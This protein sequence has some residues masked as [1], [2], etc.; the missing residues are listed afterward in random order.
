[1]P[2]DEAKLT[3][4]ALGILDDGENKVIQREIATSPDLQEELASIRSA[5]QR[6]ALAEKPI[7]PSD[8]LRD[9]VLDS[10]QTET[11][12]D[13]FIERFS[14]LFDL[15]KQSSKNLLAK[16]DHVS[17]RVWESTFFPGI[18]I[19]KFSAGPGVASDIC[20][21][22]QVKPGKLFPAHQH[23]GNEWTLIL[24]GQARDDKDRVYTAGDM[25]HYSAGSKHSFRIIGDETFIFAVNLEK[26][27]K[28]LLFR[29]FIDYLR[30]RK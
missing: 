22:V 3:E 13:G 9:L 21:I 27:N 4:Y 12:F 25:T 14:D 8:R 26:E 5:L 30:N 6:V 10:T 15:D 29:T 18:N 2:V 16:I 23:M 24:Q 20:G 1:M 19:M 28:W 17:D 11:R 7:H